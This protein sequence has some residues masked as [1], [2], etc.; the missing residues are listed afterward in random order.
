MTLPDVLLLSAVGINLLSVGLNLWSGQ[1]GQRIINQQRDQ[2]VEFSK[3]VAL[4]AFL[5][6]PE[7][8]APEK[9]REQCRQLIPKGVQLHIEEVHSRV[10]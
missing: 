10:H 4:V 1:V 8:G 5:A 7:S 6:Q 3:C 2:I 9:L